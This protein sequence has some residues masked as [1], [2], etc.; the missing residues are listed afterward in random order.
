MAGSDVNSPTDAV[1]PTETELLD[2]LNAILASKAFEN[3]VALKG[4]LQYLF[5]HRKSQLSEYSLGVEALGRRAS[6]DPQVDAT[7]R[8]QVSRLRRRLKEFYLDEGSALALRFTIPLGSHRLV[9]EDVQ[10]QS[11]LPEPAKTS[12]DSRALVATNIYPPPLSIRLRR[13]SPL[14]A[15]LSVLVVVLCGVC[16]WLGWRLAT[17]SHGSA[18]RQAQETLLPVWREFSDNNKPV[19]IV[20]PN[21][22]FFAWGMG[23]QGTMLVRNPKVNNFND[24]SS[25]AVFNS[26]DQQFGTPQLSQNYA[27]SS[28]VIASLKLM[29]YMDTR[30]VKADLT[31][32]SDTPSEILENNNI[33]LMGTPGT[34]TPFLSQ[35]HLQYFYFDP[36]AQ[37]IQ[38]KAPRSGEL[39]AYSVTNESTKR[40]IV[41][42]LIAV[43][44]GATPNSRLMILTG[45]STAA[46]VAFLTS[47]SSNQQLQEAR[48][49]AGGGPYFEAVLLSEEEGNTTLNNRLVAIRT[50]SASAGRN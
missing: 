24:R 44:P 31:I 32:S 34:L 28:D 48:R 25:I 11:P 18:Q 45:R 43:V 19:Q 29:H 27:V 2:H 17:L 14:V 7:V 37:T 3:A 42:G 38:N 9:L 40:T 30:G 46:L 47:A 26:F 5:A 39:S 41:P 10:T 23:A 21:P 4:L 33:I 35:L 6:F 13:A 16:G 1:L 8:V 22:I 15:V 20:I 50:Y 12:D 36:Q 49:R